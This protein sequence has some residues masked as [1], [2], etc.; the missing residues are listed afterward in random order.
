MKLMKSVWKEK[1]RIKNEKKEQR[2]YQ[3]R[4]LR[5]NNRKKAPSGAFLLEAFLAVAASTEAGAVVSTSA[6]QK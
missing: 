6:E 2:R 1:S 5:R 3:K 4:N